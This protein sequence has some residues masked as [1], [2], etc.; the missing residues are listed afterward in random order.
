[1]LEVIDLY[2]FHWNHDTEVHSC[3]TLM[4]LGA[5]TPGIIK[6]HAP[7]EIECLYT[8]QEGDELTP[9]S[10]PNGQSRLCTVR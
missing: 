2:C 3:V 6:Y 9:G 8:G 10:R 7:P 1:M 5:Y 4:Q